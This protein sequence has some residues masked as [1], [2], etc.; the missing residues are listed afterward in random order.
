MPVGV[1]SILGVICALLGLSSFLISM[2]ALFPINIFN[3]VKSCIVLV[4]TMSDLDDEPI[5]SI[6][7][8]CSIAIG[9]LSILFFYKIVHKGMK[10]GKTE[11]TTNYGSTQQSNNKEDQFLI[12]HRQHMFNA[13]TFGF[14][15]LNAFWVTLAWF[16]LIQL[17][18]QEVQMVVYRAM[19]S[20][21]Y[22]VA[23]DLVVL[24]VASALMGLASFFFVAGRKL[25][26]KPNH[27]NYFNIV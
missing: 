9:A 21:F 10:S 8:A 20:Q 11:E 1:L 16:L 14:I 23:Y 22:A 24:T 18:Q 19:Q 17:N 25:R 13:Y 3:S 5:P 2:I 12:K 27:V 4:K 15:F 7:F 26:N 6:F